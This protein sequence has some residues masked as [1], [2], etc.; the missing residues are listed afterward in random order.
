MP[1]FAAWLA[2]G[3]HRLTHWH[4]D[5]S[6][7]TGAG[8]CGILHGSNDD[9]LGYR[10]YEKDRDHVVVC[11]TPEDAAEVERRHSDGRGLLAVDGAGHGNLFTGDAPHVSLTMSAL[12]LLSGAH[13]R[14]GRARD[15]VGAGYYA[16]FANPVNA[17][18]T[19]R[20]LPGRRGRARSRPPPGSA[21]PTSGPGCP[22]AASTRSPGPRRRSSPATSSSPRCWRTCWPAGRASTPTSW[23]TTRSRTTP[24]SSGSTPWPC[25]AASTSRSAG[26]TG[27]PSSPRAATTWSAC[28]T[29]GRP[30][31]CRSRTG[32][33]RPSRSWS[34]GSAAPRPSSA[35][36]PTG[37]RRAAAARPPGGRRGLAGRRRAARGVRQRRA[38]RRAGCGPGCSEPARR[39]GRSRRTR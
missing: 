30:R 20:R 27:P 16:Y 34:A 2:A 14:R 8:V 7:Q 35:G 32:S 19:L 26:C 23:A 29:T 4:T 25:C 31:A 21:G 37:A 18:R 12:P 33:G 36:R 24:A 11:G 39:R 13:R 38:D 17:L 5:W 28:P 22:A 3:S 1:T 15:G 10:W 6:S 9:I